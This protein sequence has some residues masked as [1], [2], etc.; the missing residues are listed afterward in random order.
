MATW[1]PD[2]HEYY[3]STLSSLYAH[4]DSLM[5]NFHT[6]VLPAT[7]YN[8]GPQTVCLKHRDFNNLSF[9]W[10][11]ISALGSYDPQKGGHLILWECGLVIEFP[12]GST[13]LIPSAIIA[14]SNTR[15]SS[16]E[17]HYSFTQYAAGGLFRWVENKFMKAEL[18][19]NS[20]EGW[21][22]V[23]YELK[24]KTRWRFG[25]SLLSKYPGKWP[26]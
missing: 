19:Q 23:L 17:T 22:R 21:D 11:A 6:S 26:M 10:C 13:I 18:Y 14:H 16:G 15:V 2:L 7:T 20:L 8:M 5:R 12:P 9:G 3:T 24:N 4:D 1:A 25:L